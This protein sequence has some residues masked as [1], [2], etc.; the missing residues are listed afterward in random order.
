MPKVTVLY[1]DALAPGSKPIQYGPH[2]LLLWC[3]SD[4]TKR[5][6]WDLGRLVEGNPR[7]GK[8]KVRQASKLPLRDWVIALYDQDRVR[9][10]PGLENKKRARDVA[11]TLRAE[12][13]QPDRTMVVLLDKNLETLM[14]HVQSCNGQGATTDKPTPLQ[15]DLLLRQAFGPEAA[16]VRSC[17]QERMPAVRCVVDQI[18]TL[19]N[20]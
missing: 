1:E 16:H 5:P 3:V 12:S 10:M 9:D 13:A 6:I 4:R 18:T 19:L 11:E 20:D 17:L 15:R 7:K 2:L 8:E 14:K